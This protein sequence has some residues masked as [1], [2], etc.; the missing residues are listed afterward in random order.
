MDDILHRQ[1]Q[2]PRKMTNALFCSRKV[3]DARQGKGEDTKTFL[4]R[5]THLRLQDM[6]LSLIQN[7]QTTRKLQALYLNSN[8]IT[9][10]TGLQPNC[11]KTLLQLDLQDNDIVVME[12]LSSLS[13]LKR[14]SLARNCINFI[15]G[16]EHCPR[17]E[18]LDISGQRLS[19]PN[20]AVEFDKAS[21]DAMSQQLVSL[22]ASACGLQHVEHIACLDNVT[23][24]DVSNNKLQDVQDFESLLH[25]QSQR[26]GGMR[27]LRTLLTLGNPAMDAGGPRVRD[28]LVMMAECLHCLNGKIIEK[29]QRDFLMQMEA[30]KKKPKKKKAPVQNENMMNGME[31]GIRPMGF[32]D[33]SA[34]D[35]VTGGNKPLPG[36]KISGQTAFR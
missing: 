15:V 30:R 2:P 31:T 4:K 26:T 27:R 23:T 20:Q 34:Y 36:R 35:K 16:L 32:E 24:L 7:L 29:R 25:A 22:N 13:G 3:T 33:A 1:D 19:D 10:M 9:C 28:S 8:V 14:L 18:Q 11:L 21:I 6:G 5:L 12:G 17:L